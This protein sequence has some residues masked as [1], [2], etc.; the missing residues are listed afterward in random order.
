LWVQRKRNE[1]GEKNVSWKE[2]LDLPPPMKPIKTND[3]K[4][5]PESLK[6][7]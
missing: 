3:P 6:D 2:I 4:L 7:P 1:E 5:F